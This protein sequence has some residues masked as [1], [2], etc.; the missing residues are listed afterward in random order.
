MKVT[1]KKQ[2][3]FLFFMLLI[4]IWAVAQLMTVKGTVKDDKSEA[5]VGVSILE[6]GS[7]TNGT[8]TDVNG[9]FVIKV[10]RNAKLNNFVYWLQ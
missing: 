9:N 5:L 10:A 2:I 8:I 4:P 7:T 1:I 6:A 3:I